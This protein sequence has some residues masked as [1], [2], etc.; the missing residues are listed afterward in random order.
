MGFGDDLNCP[1]ADVAVL[2]LL[3]SEIH[4]MELMK[5]WMGQRAKSERNFAT[6]L[7]HM[8]ALVD[9]QP[10][11]GSDHFSQLNKSWGTLVSQ[12]D[13]LSQLMR[14]RSEELLNGP[15]SKLTLLIRDKQQLRKTFAEH[16]SFLRQELSKV[17]QTEPD[18]LKSSYRQAARDVGQAKRKF[19]EASKDK[20]RDR[21][22]ERC[23]KATVKLHESH[24]EYVLSVGGARVYQQQNHAHIQPDVLNA[25]QTLQQEMVLIVKEI[26]QEYFYISS[27]LHQEVVHIHR[28]M[29][30][31]ITSIDPLTEYDGF[32][33]HNRSAGENLACT[34]FDCSLLENTENLKPQEVQLNDL[35]M[36][37]LENKL[38]AVEDDLLCLS[39]SLI[40]QQVS[41]EQLELELEAKDGEGRKGQRV[42]QLTKRLALEECRQQVA[43][44]QGRRLKMEVQRFILKTTLEQLGSREPPPALVLEKDTYQS[45][46]VNSSNADRPLA[47]QDWYHG[48]VPRLEVHQLLQCDGDF[49]VR[50]SLEKQGDVLSVHWDGSCKHFLIQNINNE[51]RLDGE[52]FCSI[53]QLIHHLLSSR[54]HITR[55]CHIELRKPVLKDKWVLEHEGVLLGDII[56]QGN[57]GEVYRGTLRFNNTPVAV[58]ACK[59]NLAAEL[60]SKF[61]ME[62][63]ILK[64]Y[65][66]PNIVKLI[67]VCTQKEPIYIIMELV[68]GGDLLSFLRQD[69]PNQT[70]KTLVRMTENVAAGMEYLERKKCIHRDLAARNCLVTDGGVVK[71]SDFG[72]S[73]QQDDGVYSAEGSLRQIPIKWTAPEALNYGRYTTESDVWSFGVLLWEVFSLGMGPYSSMNNQQAREEV[74]KG[75]RMPAPRDCPLEVSTLMSSCWQHEPQ[76]RPSFHKLRMALYDIWKNKT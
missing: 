71:I 75:Y 27:M 33:H 42:Y 21:A 37:P 44:L 15:V 62:A 55:K 36:E 2:K 73:R 45:L 13:L 25:L 10:T 7:H 18:R 8:A 14:R 4:M 40:P 52:S 35:T 23:L 46:L 76:N 70:P 47:Q 20:E 24:N 43:L 56:G 30:T 1:H 6:Q 66:H 5:K 53:P 65:D 19:Q 58:K 31:A 48:A 3:D 59:E 17:T 50:T 29:S 63:R 68:E 49:L 61:L 74:D 28:E 69:G 16:W 38:S 54:Q 51:Y 11:C 34:E 57:F 32:I 12:T 41:V 39:R 9:K 22:K 64:Q 72:M 67:G 26:L 60:R